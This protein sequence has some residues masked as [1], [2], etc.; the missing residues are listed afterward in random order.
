MRGR[1]ARENRN[2][3][4]QPSGASRLGIVAL[5]PANR[6]STR[7]ARSR[8]LA[9]LVGLLI[10]LAALYALNYA[11]TRELPPARHADAQRT[12]VDV[13]SARW[14]FLFVAPTV[15][16]IALPGRIYVRPGRP[17][18]LATLAHEVAHVRQW[19]RYGTLPFAR[20]HLG[21]LW[22]IYVRRDYQAPTLERAAWLEAQQLH[23][24]LLPSPDGPE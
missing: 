6:T 13:L 11:T 18:P 17:V 7:R 15:A 23:L 8:P 14:P 3:T 24:S 2:V 1:R 5:R 19:R 9:A 16:A 21:D 20:K 12:D 4:S 22:T 10:G